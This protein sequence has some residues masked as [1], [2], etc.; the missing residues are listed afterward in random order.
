VAGI[1]SLRA[2][3][4]EAVRRAIAAGE[5]ELHF[6]PIAT[7][8][9]G[10]IEALEA[11]VRWN[12]PTEGMLTPALFLPAVEAS[13]AAWLFT[14]HVLELAATHARDWLA[15]GHPSQVAVNISA[16]LLNRRL[17]AELPE[18]LAEVGLSPRWLML[19][20]TESAVMDDPD[21]ATR[22]LTELAAFGLGGI[23]IDDFGTGH[24]SL[25]RLRD[26]PIDSLKLDRSF[27]AELDRG[28]DPAFV[29]SVI[30]LG[31]YLGLRVVAEGVE[32]EEAWRSLAHFGCDAGQ[33]YWLSPP[34]PADE[35]CSWLGRHD[36]AGLA[37]RGAVG[38]RRQGV[39]RRSLDRIA[40]AFDRAPDP[41]LMSDQAHRWVAINAAARELLGVRARTLLARHVDDTARGADGNELTR[42]VDA[43]AEKPQL[44]GT[45]EVTA[46]DGSRTHVSYELR[47]SLVPGHHVWLLG[48]AESAK[49]V[50]P[51]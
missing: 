49:P 3:S 46:A 19:E 44:S 18:L 29:R 35:L 39:G 4:A 31:H 40:D 27:V 33:G 47:R 6:Q 22:A 10:E 17:T 48:P 8:T 28:V 11:L 2:G 37:R 34:L 16:Q 32:D 23:A 45:C 25:G 5:F 21:S 7:I 26:L 20:I 51:P 38:D 12:H 13:D 43:L 14:L 9:T 1:R 50:G 15:R 30:D 24:S 36:A 42:L 41:M